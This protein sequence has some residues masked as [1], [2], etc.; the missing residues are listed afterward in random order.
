MDEKSVRVRIPAGAYEGQVLRVSGRG[1]EG[2][3]E[4]GDLLLQLSVNTPEGWRRHGNDLVTEKTI[5]I[6]EAVLGGELMIEDPLGQKLR[7][8]VPPSS[9]SGK[10]LRLRGY[11]MTKE[12][13]G[14]RG[15]LYARLQI[16]VPDDISHR[17]RQLYM[18]LAELEGEKAVKPET[19]EEQ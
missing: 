9:S 8:R 4:N 18:E 14:A 12:A 7:V 6:T 19:E 10:M 15:D 17:E 1:R 16:M 11:G 5:S 3:Q 2:L 13:G